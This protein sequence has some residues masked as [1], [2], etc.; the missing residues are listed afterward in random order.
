MLDFLTNLLFESL[1]LLLLVEAVVIAVFLAIHRRHGTKRTR[2]ALWLAVAA[3]LAQ[4]VVQELVVTDREAVEDFVHTLALAVDDG[5]MWALSERFDDGVIIKESYFGSLQG[6][7][8]V[9][10]R[11][12]AVLQQNSVKR[13]SVGGARIEVLGDVAKVICQVMADIRM[14]GTS[15]AERVPSRWELEIVRTPTGWK[16]R[17]ASG[18]FGIG[19][20]GR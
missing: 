18:E 13:V 2:I 15:S 20:I 3:C 14:G 19:N 10:V 5:D 16:L 11:A 1:I 12:Q 8:A 17:K 9:M 7:D 4:I 6:K